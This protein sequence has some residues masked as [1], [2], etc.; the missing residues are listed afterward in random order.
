MADRDFGIG[1]NDEPTDGTTGSVA[2]SRQRL[3]ACAY[4]P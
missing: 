3:Y 4:D 1:I 2:G